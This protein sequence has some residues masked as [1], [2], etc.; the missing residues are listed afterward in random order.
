VAA[1]YSIDLRWKI[2]RACER[3]TASQREVAEFFGV[4]LATVENLLRL[5]RHT[6]QV[7]PLRKFRQY[8]LRVD[9]ANGERIR[10]WLQEQPD[11][12]L[13]ELCERLEVRSGIKISVPTMCRVIQ[14]LGLRRKKRVSMP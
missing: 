6:G 7:I 3:G 8:A 11:L 1:P 4:S 9:R 14:Q 13:A 5:Y 2:V 12:T 10:Q